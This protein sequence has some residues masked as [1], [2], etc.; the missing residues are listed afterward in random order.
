MGIVS[1]F[2]RGNLLEGSFRT[3]TEWEARELLQEILSDPRGSWTIEEL[4]EAF[5]QKGVNFVA[6]HGSEPI[7]RDEITATFRKLGLRLGVS[8]EVGELKWKLYGP[9][10]P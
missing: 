4:Q 10:A 2:F 5:R 9:D 1:G 6:D 8:A 7:M 3:V